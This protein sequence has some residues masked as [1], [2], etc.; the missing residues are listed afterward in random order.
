MSILFS[1]VLFVFFVLLISWFRP[2]DTK[3]YTSLICSW[4]QLSLWVCFHCFII[5]W[6]RHCSVRGFDSS[7]FYLLRHS[8]IS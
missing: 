4:P 8:A 5:C 3:F 6:L 2:Y 7:I 1:L